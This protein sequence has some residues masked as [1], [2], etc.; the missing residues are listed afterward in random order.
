[1]IY[2]DNKVFLTDEEIEIVRDL[3]DSGVLTNPSSIVSILYSKGKEGGFTE[4]R[5]LVCK[6]L[7]IKEVVKSVVHDDNGEQIILT[8]Y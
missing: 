5:K 8:D 6:L 4:L 3:F 1:M 7:K 2:G